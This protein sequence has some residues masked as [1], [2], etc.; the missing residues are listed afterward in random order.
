MGRLVFLDLWVHSGSAFE[1]KVI[2]SAWG[3]AGLVGEREIYYLCS[4]KAL[5]EEFGPLARSSQS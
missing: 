4:N 1:A 5:V 3:I 2:V